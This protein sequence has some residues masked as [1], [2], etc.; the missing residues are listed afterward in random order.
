MN[1][2]NNCQSC[3]KKLRPIHNDWKYRH[4]HNKCFDTLYDQLISTHMTLNDAE[5]LG[6]PDNIINMMKYYVEH[7]E[8]ILKPDSFISQEE[9]ER[10]LGEI[11]ER[12][13]IYIK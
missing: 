13:N 7:L 5:Y 12:L 1:Y 6:I 2:F 4:L 8:K 9:K 3:G 10:I 11:K